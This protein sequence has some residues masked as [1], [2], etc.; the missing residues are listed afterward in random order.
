LLQYADDPNFLALAGYWV[1]QRKAYNSQQNVKYLGHI[2]AP[3]ELTLA[4][5]R[6]VFLKK[7]N[8]KETAQN[9]SGN[10]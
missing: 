6:K 2:L 9:L 4:E 7:N 8:L 1:S 3:E 5:K 10:D